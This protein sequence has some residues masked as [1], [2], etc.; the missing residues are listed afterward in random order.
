MEKAF[1][2]W[3][4]NMFLLVVII[5]FVL[6]LRKY[7]RVALA[8]AASFTLACSD[9]VMVADPDQSQQDQL[10][11]EQE[12]ASSTEEEAQ[13]VHEDIPQVPSDQSYVEINDNVPYFTNEDLA[14]V[15]AYEEIGDFDSLG[16]TTAA[17]ALLGTE[18]MPEEERGDISGIHPTGW[19]QRFYANVPGGALYNRS[20]LVGHQFTGNDQPENLMTG[21]Q[22]FNQTAM[23]PFENFVADYIEQTDN[24]VRYRITPVYDGDNLLASGIYMEAFSIEDNGE[25]VQFNIFVPNRQPG[26]EINYQD[27]S[28]SGPQGPLEE[29]DVQP[30]QA[31]P[32]EENPEAPAGITPQP[33]QE[34]SEEDATALDT[35]DDGQVS[36]KE[37]QAAG[38]SM[39]IYSDHW[40][41]PYMLD[42]DGDGMVGEGR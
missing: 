18:L 15:E 11:Q 34:G 40:L 29:G 24:H 23:L 9:Q 21:T 4:E 22:W 32:E 30:R 25:G 10:F 39:P 36:V 16:R 7:P 6:L 1:Y 2:F 17:N 3:G 33:S 38:Y 20:H 14:Q 8:L 26:V 28:S 13:E 12:S 41:Y 31:E 19:Q 35:N 42:G 27:G 37:A 5:L